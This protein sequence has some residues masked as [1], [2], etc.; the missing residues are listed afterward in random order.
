MEAIVDFIDQTIKNYEDD[1]KLEAIA[2]QVNE[3]M[4]GKPLFT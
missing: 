2:L 3:M 1:T 4:G